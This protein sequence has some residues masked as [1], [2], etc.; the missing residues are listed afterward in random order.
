[1]K[2]SRDECLLFFPNDLCSLLNNHIGWLTTYSNP[3][4]RRFDAYLWHQPKSAHRGIHPQTLT[5]AHT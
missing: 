1:M 2:L 5:Y 3:S 4:S